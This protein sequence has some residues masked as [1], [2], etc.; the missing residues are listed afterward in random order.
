MTCLKLAELNTMKRRMAQLKSEA[1]S[2]K[3]RQ[4]EQDLEKVHHLMS[5]I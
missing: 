2:M 3:N 4:H 5:Q 1:Y